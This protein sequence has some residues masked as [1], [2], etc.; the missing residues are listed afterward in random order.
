MHCEK[1]DKDYFIEKC[2]LKKLNAHTSL[3]EWKTLLK[4]RMILSQFQP[5]VGS[6]HAWLGVKWLEYCTAQRCSL[7]WNDMILEELQRTSRVCKNFAL[8]DKIKRDKV[9]Y[10]VNPIDRLKKD[11]QDNETD[12]LIFKE[13][14]I[15]FFWN[16]R[17]RLL[18][19]SLGLLG[20]NWFGKL[21]VPEFLQFWR[22]AQNVKHGFSNLNFQVREALD[23]NKVQ[24]LKNYLK[25]GVVYQMV[26]VD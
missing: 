23:K 12:F 6:I 22:D 21:G 7:M 20:F 15:L 3:F 26:K 25:F 16:E 13:T 17:L 19:E 4:N 18:W 5:V 1:K 14:E 9:S 11:I 10:H 2:S 8:I 24:R